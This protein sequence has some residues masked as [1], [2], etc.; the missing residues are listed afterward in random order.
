MLA[1]SATLLSLQKIQIAEQ[2][3]IWQSRALLLLDQAEQQLQQGHAGFARS[4]AQD[5]AKKLPSGFGEIDVQ[6]H[7]AGIAIE[8]LAGRKQLNTIIW[9]PTEQ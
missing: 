2:N 7:Q 1:A 9:I 6:P 4:W 3:V 5:V 8:W